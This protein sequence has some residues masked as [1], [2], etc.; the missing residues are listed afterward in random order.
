MFL[1]RPNPPRKSNVLLKELLDQ[2]V[3]WLSAAAEHARVRIVVDAGPGRYV[4]ADARRVGQV[5]HNIIVN[6]IQAMPIGG[7][8]TIA[9]RDSTISFA[10]TGPGFSR[11]ALARWAEMMYS[12]KE[13]GMGIGLSVAEQIIRAHGGR[14]CVANRTEGG[15]VVRVEL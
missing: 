10:D 11:T 9:I 15:A 2:S 4:Q 8:L 1:A 12:E 3:R 6:A 5:F 7:I 14:I 13:G